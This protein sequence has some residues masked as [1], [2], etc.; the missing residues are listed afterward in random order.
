MIGVVDQYALKFSVGDSKDFLAEGQLD[1][2]TLIEEAG[3]ILPTFQLTFSLADDNIFKDLNEGN[4]IKMSFGPSTSE[5]YDVELFITKVKT[6]RIAE[7][8]RQFDIL[9]TMAKAEYLTNTSCKIYDKKSALEVIKEVTG[10]YFSP[11]LNVPTSKDKQYW[12]QPN[13]SDKQFVNELLMHANGGDTFYVAGIGS[14]NKFRVRDMKKLTSE[15]YKWRITNKIE[16]AATD[17]MDDK[18]YAFTSNA[19]LLNH[20]LGYG[21]DRLVHTLE[22]D[23]KELC[24][25][26]AMK[27][28]FAQAKNLNRNSK[29]KRRYEKFVPISSE[30]VH[31]DY[32]KSQ[33]FNLQNLAIFSSHEIEFEVKDVYKNFQLFDTIMVKET[34]PEDASKDISTEYFTGYYVITKIVRNVSQRLLVTTIF[35]CRECLN[36]IHGSLK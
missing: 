18:G 1:S 4:N 11:D 34:H 16:D 33:L 9:G 31:K 3:N 15:K 8:R 35:A 6:V 28:I 29:I 21:K 7:H 25:P 30:N 17:I 19:G 10:K 2:F 27:P 5:L 13:S 12:I 23:V 36:N 26:D 14:D 20:I 32:W 22:T 24:A